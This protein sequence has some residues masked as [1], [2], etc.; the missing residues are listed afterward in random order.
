MD[1]E[2]FTFPEI[3]PTLSARA[4]FAVYCSFRKREAPDPRASLVAQ[5]GVSQCETGL[6]PRNRVFVGV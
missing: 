1:G 4:I 5:H 6:V 2:I 3:L